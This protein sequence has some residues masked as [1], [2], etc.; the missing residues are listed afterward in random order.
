MQDN[1]HLEDAKR[2]LLDRLL[3]GKT[4][5]IPD[6]ISRIV[7]RASGAPA[8]LSWSQEQVYRHAQLA[9][10]FAPDS[11]LYNESITIHRTGPI[12]PEVLERSLVEIL[13]RHEAWRTTFVEMN[14]QLVQCVHAVQ[15]LRLDVV[16]LRNLPESER[17]RTALKI[18]QA[19]AQQPFNLAEGPLLRF[20]LVRLSELEHRLYL[21]AHQI[22][23]DGVSA[24]QVF[25]PE[26]VALYEAFVSGNPSPLPEPR[27][28]YSDYAY[29]QRNNLQN[30]ALSEHLNYWQKQLGAQPPSLHMP[31]DHPRPEVQTFRGAIQPFA[32]GIRVSDAA[33][34]LTRAEGTTLFVT[35]L[36]AFVALLSGYTSQKELVIGTVATTRN[37]AEV[38]RLL[39]YFLN[40]VVLYFRLARHLTF[41][42][43]LR[44]VHEAVVDALSHGEMPFHMLVD[45][46][47]AET[48]LSRNPLYQVQFS[49]E[50]PLPALYPGWNLTPMDL[51]SGGAKLDL[52]LVLD[53]RPS[54]TLGRLQYNPDL[55]EAAS[56]QRMAQH[57]QS[58]L[59]TATAAPEKQLSELAQYSFCNEFPHLRYT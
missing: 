45:V 33:R 25:L 4:D 37:H 48:D 36:A 51:Q 30:G 7:R 21:T 53:D 23:L 57:Y 44:H 42:A 2:A 58:L 49:L 54:G 38:Q 13:R 43:V 40:P 55:F 19:S 50:P 12:A 10:R 52:Y 16:D 31:T 35:Y 9:G 3:R 32:M 14:G 22:V 41:R 59:E 11:R 1:P 26:L 24:Y 6:K 56:M 5:P 27:V 18:G 15:E 17:E 29:W 20:Q 28:Q 8:P 39:G 46:A 34:A 47:Q